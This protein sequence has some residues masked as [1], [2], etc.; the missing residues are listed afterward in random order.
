MNSEPTKL[1]RGKAFHKLIQQEWLDTSKDG[2]PRPERSIRK[3]AGG[4]GR[5]D[6]LVEELGDF[7]SVIEIKSTDWD[8]ITEANIERNIRRQIR[9]I[10]DYIVAMFA[11]PDKDIC[12]GV[13]FPFPPIV[14]TKRALVESRFGAE[15]IQVVW[16][17]EVIGWDRKADL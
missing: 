13:I 8:S 14:L 11:E 2:K 1:A 10:W 16:H 7:I 9:Q 4:F 15:C 3:V 12:P 6:I 5:V 17:N